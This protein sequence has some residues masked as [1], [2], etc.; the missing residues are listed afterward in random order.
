MIRMTDPN[1]KQD[2]G[3]FDYANYNGMEHLDGTRFRAIDKNG[4]LAFGSGKLLC[5]EC[6]KLPMWILARKMYEGDRSAQRAYSMALKMVSTS[7]EIE[8]T[9]NNLRG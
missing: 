9:I 6:W 3:I 1:E 4:D 2:V 5:R 8:S 7:D